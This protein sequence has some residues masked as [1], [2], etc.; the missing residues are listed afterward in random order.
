LKQPLD[1]HGSGLVTLDNRFDDIGRKV[2][3]SQKPTDVGVMDYVEGGMW[4]PRTLSNRSGA[5]LRKQDFD[6]AIEDLT[7]VLT[8]RPDNPSVFYTRAQAYAAKKEYER[9]RRD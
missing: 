8:L 3:K 6:H 7:A 1:R 2:S 5:Y 9:A 4:T